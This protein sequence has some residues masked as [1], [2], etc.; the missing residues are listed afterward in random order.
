MKKGRLLIIDDEPELR[1]LMTRLFRL[2]HYDVW[3]VATE[4]EGCDIL[5]DEDIHVIL[6]D[7]MLGN[8]NGI[9]LLPKFK[10]INPLCEVVMMT[11]FGSIEDG[12]QAIKTGAFDY[13]T[14]GDDDNKVLPV[15]ER[16]MS[17]A[18]MAYKL[19]RLEAQLDQRFGFENLIGESQPLHDAINIAKKVA[20]TNTPVL[21]VGETGTGKELFAQAIH[22]SGDR[23][24]KPFVA[25]NCSAFARDLLESEMFG[26]KAGAFTGAN[27]NKKGLFEEADEGTIFLDEIGKMDVKLQAKLLRVL[28]SQ[29]F[30]KQGD[31][32]QTI[33][34]VRII[35]ATNLNLEKE[36]NIGN[37]R[38]D[39][40]YRISVM[41]I[42][43]PPLR[44]RLSD[45]PALTRFFVD[46][47]ARKMNRNITAVEPKFL[48]KLQQYKFPGNIRELRN[49]IERCIIL[50][51]G[52]TL[53]ASGLPA[54]FHN[55]D[56][57]AKISGET[58][59][60]SLSEMEKRHIQHVLEMCDGNK[61]RA[62]K[63]LGIGTATLYRK[64]DSYGI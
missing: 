41:K 42:R 29:S 62:A 31:T 26:Y 7:V 64:I 25:V 44:E 34:D 45:I 51:E 9:E 5:A 18:K 1:K 47:F 8:V 50:N 32:K 12:V 38:D 49:V 58:G 35:A 40:Y 55:L 39:L 15:V 56:F 57:S 28:E 23:A 16:A 14:K 61:T 30:I 59:A 10:E 3:D 20:E 52:Q 22:Y 60:I 27:K 2:E 37:F 17:R 11:A 6:C 54:E 13:I 48:E 63:M 21:L 4:R 33:V 46:H 43:I 36:I 53:K 19:A 24:S